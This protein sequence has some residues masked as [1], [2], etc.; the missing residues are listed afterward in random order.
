MV[1]FSTSIKTIFI[2]IELITSLG[3]TQE[4]MTIEGYEQ[5]IYT[6]EVEA[7]QG[8]ELVQEFAYN[9]LFGYDYVSTMAVQEEVTYP[10]GV[11]G[12][13]YD[14]YGRP[15][16]IVIKDHELLSLRSVHTPVFLV[17]DNDEVEIRD[18]QVRA[19]LVHGEIR[20][21]L[22]EINDDY[23]NRGVGVYTRWFGKYLYPQE[24]IGIYR[25]EN[26]VVTE[27]ITHNERV[28]L[29]GMAFQEK[30]YVISRKI[31]SDEPIYQVGDSIQVELESDIQIE[32]VKEAFQTG[33]WLVYEGENVAQDYEPFVGYTT[34]LQP[35]TAIGITDQEE[36][37]VKVIDGRQAGISQGVTGKQLATLM[38]EEGCVFAT[39]LDG[40]SSSVVVKDG[41]VINHPSGGEEKAVAHAL[42]FN[43]T[44]PKELQK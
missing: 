25:V 5:N 41:K 7:S 16:G 35:R 9:G 31:F 2:L 36:I 27:I 37:V 10:L 1:D 11:N 15:Q 24:N 21:P 8:G 39:Y 12:M 6:I 14:G 29:E 34:S 40:G 22:Y 42:F 30:N 38:Q 32:S 26:N 3:L 28:P 13:F 20:Q 43:R 18:I 44:M 17:F 4:H 19:Y 33:G 23:E